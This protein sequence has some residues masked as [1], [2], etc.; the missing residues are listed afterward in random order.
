MQMIRL[1]Q[2]KFRNL[3][4]FVIN[5]NQVVPAQSRTRCNSYPVLARV[6]ISYP[7]IAKSYKTKKA[8]KH[9]I[10]IKLKPEGAY[11]HLWMG[12]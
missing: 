7:Q 5:S 12:L 10:S 11:P 9:S 8:N 3:T 4:E 6:Y 2:T 1:V